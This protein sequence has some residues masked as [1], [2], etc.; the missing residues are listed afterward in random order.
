MLQRFGAVFGIALA[1]AVFS[2]YGRIGTPTT[3]TDGFRP[4][5]MVAGVLAILGALA[6]L[7]ISTSA[8]RAPAAEAAQ[9]VV[10]SAIP[11]AA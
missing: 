3:F 4:A 9:P 8:T 11:V 6:G 2:S 7:A 10:Q 1:S 5:L